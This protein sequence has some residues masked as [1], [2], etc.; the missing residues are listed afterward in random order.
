[1]SKLTIVDLHDDRSL[2]CRVRKG[3]AEAVPVA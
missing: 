1:V 3:Y 2:K